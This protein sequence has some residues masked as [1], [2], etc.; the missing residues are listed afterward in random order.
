MTGWEIVAI[1]A[2]II[3]AVLGVLHVVLTFWGLHLKNEDARKTACVIM[4]LPL[5]TP[6]KEFERMH[7]KLHQ[8]D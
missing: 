6:M 4:G 8:D 7:K 3:V 1:V 5:D 2:A